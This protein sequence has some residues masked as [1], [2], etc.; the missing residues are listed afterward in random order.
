M[1]GAPAAGLDRHADCYALVSLLL[2]YPEPGLLEEREAV[3]AAAAEIPDGTQRA[4][5]GRF[6]AY[7]SGASPAELRRDYVA[8]FDL[9]KGC[10]LYL[11][12]YLYGDRRQRGMTF[13]RLKQLYEAAG[14]ELTSRELPDYLPLMLEFG[15]R[16]PAGYGEAVLGEFRASLELLRLGLRS[17][18][19]PYVHLLDAVVAGLPGMTR[20]EQGAV[21]RLAAE[22]PP[23]EQVGLEPFAPPEVMPPVTGAPLDPVG[24]AWPGRGGAQGRMAS[25]APLKRE[26]GAR[27]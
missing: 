23:D 3:L 19:S 2:R 17:Y 14:W 4:A 10:G 22:G 18:G 9:Q 11:S 20:A 24:G 15:A 16:A 26:E 12:H 1:T 6:L 25:T 5:V 13:L 7:W 21:R 8:T 27:R